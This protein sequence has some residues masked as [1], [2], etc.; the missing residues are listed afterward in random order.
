[1]DKQTEEKLKAKWSAVAS[2]VLDI[3]GLI[4]I[5]FNVSSL[6]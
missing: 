6:N 4:L 2:F 1:M 5:I 3:I